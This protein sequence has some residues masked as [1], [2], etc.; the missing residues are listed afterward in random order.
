MISWGFVT[1]YLAGRVTMR[2]YGNFV[3]I[4]NKAASLDKL[5]PALIVLISG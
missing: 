1:D 3:L 5:K 2:L 4:R